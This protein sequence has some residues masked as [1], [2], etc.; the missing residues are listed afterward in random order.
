MNI[1]FPPYQEKIISVMLILGVILGVVYDLFKVKRHIFGSKY[2]FVF[3]DDVLFSVSSVTAFLMSVFIV[4]NGI[5]RWFEAFLCFIGFLL[6]R[7]LLSRILLRCMYTVADIIIAVVKQAFSLILF[8]FIYLL[9]LF[10]K[11]FFAPTRLCIFRRVS[12]KRITSSFHRL[13][14]AGKCT[15]EK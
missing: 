5:F 12:Q 13:S 11:C 3:I 15:Y 14:I 8:P 10:D 7:V 6:Y 9:K 1:F 2:V 4:N